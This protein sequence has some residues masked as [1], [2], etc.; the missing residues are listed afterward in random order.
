HVLRGREVAAG[1]RAQ[2]TGC[3]PGEQ[4]PPTCFRGDRRQCRVTLDRPQYSGGDSLRRIVAEP[5]GRGGSALFALLLGGVTSNEAGGG[6]ERGVDESGTQGG[7]ADVL[8]GQ[9]GPQAFRQGQHAGFRGGVGRQHAR[10]QVRGG[11]G[12]VDDRP[13]LAS[14]LELRSE[15]AATVDHA[16]QVH[17]DDV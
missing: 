12:D 14:F 2:Q 13:A 8:V 7:D 3:H 1:D 9:L 16:P 17:V 6:G 10:R 15:R 5:I 11:G 4:Q